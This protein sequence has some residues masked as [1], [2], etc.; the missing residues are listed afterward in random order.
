MLVAWGDLASGHL[1]WTDVVKL[2]P[3]HLIEESVQGIDPSNGPEPDAPVPRRVLELLRKQLDT[4]VSLWTNDNAIQ[5]AKAEEQHA[6]SDWAQKVL[7]QAKRVQEHKRPAAG[8]DAEV[9]QPSSKPRTAW[10]RPARSPSPAR[11]A[12]TNGDVPAT[13]LD[14]TQID[15]SAA[16]ADPVPE[17][18][19]VMTVDA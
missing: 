19:A 12:L 14:A 11:V 9:G 18:G 17:A 2:M 5:A 15:A 6:R 8:A 10:P 3:F 4:I 13:Q 16:G 7:D 1:H